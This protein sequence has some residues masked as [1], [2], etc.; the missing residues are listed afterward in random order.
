[1]IIL[2][3]FSLSISQ[4]VNKN[5]Y[6]A[7]VDSI[8]NHSTIIAINNKHETI[9]GRD[10]DPK[11]SSEISKLKLLIRKIIWEITT[12]PGLRFLTRLIY[13]SS[14]ISYFDVQNAVAFTIDDG[15]CGIDNNI[16]CMVNEVRQLF[17]SYDAHATF[18]VAGSHCKYSDINT[19]N[20][21][22]EDGNEIANHNMMDWPYDNYS[23][24]E[25]EYD[26]E[27]TKNILSIYNQKYSKWYRAPF[28][29]YSYSMQ[30]V[31]EKKNLIHVIPD[32][33]A[34]DT[35]I[36]D[37]YWIS[38]HILRKVKPGS[39]IL[40][41]MPERGIREWNYKAIELTLKGLQEKKLKVLNLTELEA[42]EN[43]NFH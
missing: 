5:R 25:F 29:K 35:Y 42:L 9:L 39:I 8:M 23:L 16:G 19:I 2:L 11:Q 10:N 24:E 27:L 22:I 15:F 13:P 38:E 6:S 14:T 37:P 28:G 18:F 20:L 34:H 36:P 33:F 17:K 1:M 7:Y 40:I 26:L 30:K 3:I 12:M 4:E 31:I 32:V 43:I 21:L 41:H